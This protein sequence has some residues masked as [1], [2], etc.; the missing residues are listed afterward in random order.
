MDVDDESPK[1][2]KSDKD[3]IPAAERKSS[4]QKEK[5]AKEKE[6]EQLPTENIDWG[7]ITPD[8]RE[9][10]KERH[11]KKE[12]ELAKTVEQLQHGSALYPL[13]R[14]RM[15]RRYWVF[16]SM[17]GL[18][19]EDQEQHVPDDWFSPVEQTSKT[20]PFQSD[21]LPLKARPPTGEEKSTGSDK[22]NHESLDH[23]KDGGPAGLID[24]PADNKN[25]QPRVLTENTNIG[26]SDDVTITDIEDK[27]GIS[28]VN[29]HNLVSQRNSVR[30]SF[31]SSPEQLDKLINSLNPRGFREGPLKMALLDQKT[32]LEESLQGTETTWLCKEGTGLTKSASQAKLLE[33]KVGGKTKQ[34]VV[35]NA[36]AEE[37]LELNLR[38]SLLDLEE[39][40]LFGTLG[41]LKVRWCIMQL[42]RHGQYLQTAKQ[43][44]KIYI[45]Y[46]KWFEVCG[47]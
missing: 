29:I 33:Y 46:I 3:K 36:S 34:G 41:S 12:M 31:Y 17:G 39:R 4:R 9:N 24:S 5:V 37:F 20:N 23:S 8:E 35:N 40:I 47:N 2:E 16:R 22:E 32:L 18:F 19:V 30:W 10:M 27:S 44:Y 1:G 21:S 11:V 7:N 28:Y 6:L 43:L 45:V 15:F 38:E 42:S 14:D 26:E 13:G 25:P